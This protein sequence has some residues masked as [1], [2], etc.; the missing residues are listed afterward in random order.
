MSGIAYWNPTMEPDKSGGLQEFR[1]ARTCLGWGQDMSR[2]AY[3][4]P[5]RRLNMSGFS[6]NLDWK[7]FSMI[8]IS[9]THL[10]HPP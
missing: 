9:P 1:V 8:C 5:V 3:W 4:N 10:M 2:N 7:V 6:S